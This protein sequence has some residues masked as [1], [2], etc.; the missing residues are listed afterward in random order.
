M[1]SYRRLSSIR[2]TALLLLLLGLGNILVGRSKGAYYGEAVI[3]ARR[4]AISQ[5]VSLESPGVQRLVSRQSFYKIVYVGGYAFLA[6]ALALFAV[7]AAR[8][9]RRR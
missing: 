1:N 5:E 7:D 8:R 4:E 3:Q 2:V 9:Q 6:T